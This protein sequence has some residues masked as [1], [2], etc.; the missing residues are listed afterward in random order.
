MAEQKQYVTIINGAG[1]TPKK[2]KWN[3]GD[4]RDKILQKAKI[5][6]SSSE[7]ASVDGRTLKHGFTKITAG[8][9]IVIAGKPRN[10]K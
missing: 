9:T 8:S 6:L 5:T 10:G 2:V 3:K 4:T 1:S 7:T